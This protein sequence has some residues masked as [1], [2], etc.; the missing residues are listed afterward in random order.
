MNTFGS[1]A[2]GGLGA[3]QSAHHHLASNTCHL[4]H[5]PVLLVCTATQL[6]RKGARGSTPLLPHAPPCDSRCLLLVPPALLSRASPGAMEGGRGAASEHVGRPHAS[7]TWCQQTAVTSS[8]KCI[9]LASHIT[10]LSMLPRFLH[11]VITA[12]TAGS[13]QYNPHTPLTLRY[14]PQVLQVLLGSVTCGRASI[15]GPSYL[16][17]MAASGVSLVLVAIPCA[18]T[19]ALCLCLAG[20][21][22]GRGVNADAP[23]RLSPVAVQVAVGKGRRLGERLATGES[24]GE[25]LASQAGRSHGSGS[26]G[27]HGVR[28]QQLLST[29]PSH[30]GNLPF[31]IAEAALQW[32]QMVLLWRVSRWAWPLKPEGWSTGGRESGVHPLTHLLLPP[33]SL[34]SQQHPAWT[35]VESRPPLIPPSPLPS[36][37]TIMALCMALVGTVPSLSSLPQF[38]PS[39]PSLGL[40]LPP[41]VSPLCLL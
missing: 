36:S 29:Q 20:G 15:S 25:G 39:V 6:E 8:A 1:N 24:I 37:L 27:G 22:E 34:P 5:S 14:P 4:Q 17:D 26:G 21:G 2:F 9:H 30:T 33:F 18:L 41:F 11:P 7:S 38:P 16:P 28:R 10:P 31:G 19:A 13:T 32:T 23:S 3:Y 35:T 12:A 40:F